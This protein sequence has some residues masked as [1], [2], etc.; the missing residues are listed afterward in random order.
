MAQG[1]MYTSFSNGE[2]RA[3]AELPSPYNPEASVDSV[4][5]YTPEQNFSVYQ[6]TH[7]AIVEAAQ[8]SGELQ[9]LTEVEIERRAQ[10]EAKVEHLLREARRAEIYA[11]NL[12]TK[13][14]CTALQKLEEKTV[15]TFGFLYSPQGDMVAFD[16]SRFGSMNPADW[17]VVCCGTA[18]E[19]YGARVTDVY[20]YT[21]ETHE[22]LTEMGILP[23]AIDAR[24]VVTTELEQGG[25]A[26]YHI[27]CYEGKP[28]IVT[29]KILSPHEAHGEPTVYLDEWDGIDTAEA[30][31]RESQ[32]NP[33]HDNNKTTLVRVA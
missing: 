8:A 22:K 17:H 6:A 24:I 1:E 10:Q 30:G 4:D 33:A 20:Q 7:D 23:A 3:S 31:A 9:P 21:P 32:D 15:P 2:E 19:P 16:H 27:D 5:R 14:T 28:P 12:P 25:E 11:R 26:V 18:G 29:G 13:E